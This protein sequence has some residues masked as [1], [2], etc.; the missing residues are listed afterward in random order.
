MDN[1]KYQGARQPA[2]DDAWDN[3]GLIEERDMAPADTTSSS[4][5]SYSSGILVE[6]YYGQAATQQA[7]TGAQQ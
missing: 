3:Y 5:S 2:A 7:S 1:P 4:S 6:T